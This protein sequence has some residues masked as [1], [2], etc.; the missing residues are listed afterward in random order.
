VCPRLGG[1]GWCAGQCEREVFVPMKC[2]W[3]GG[4]GMMWCVCAEG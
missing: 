1:V 4:G 3:G 2:V